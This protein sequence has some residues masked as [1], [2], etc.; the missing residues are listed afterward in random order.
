LL[1]LAT[2]TLGGGYKEDDDGGDEDSREFTLQLS[3]LQKEYQLTK[4]QQLLMARV[5]M[6]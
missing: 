1:L 5:L 3:N 2:G 6:S 4:R